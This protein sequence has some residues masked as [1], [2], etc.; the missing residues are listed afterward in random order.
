M[1]EVSESEEELHVVGD[2]NMFCFGCFFIAWVL[3][4]LV[5]DTPV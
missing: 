4:F 2:K 1:V 3:L 5:S